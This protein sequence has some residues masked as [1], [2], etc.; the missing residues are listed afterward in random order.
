LVKDVDVWGMSASENAHFRL[1]N[2]GFVFQDHHP[3]SYCS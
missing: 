3:S 1:S 2:I